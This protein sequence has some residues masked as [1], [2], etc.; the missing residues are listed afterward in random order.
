M[1]GRGLREKECKAESSSSI[2]IIKWN[3]VNITDNN[4]IHVIFTLV[5]DAYIYCFQYSSALAPVL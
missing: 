2:Q 4:L 5:F 1:G 3:N